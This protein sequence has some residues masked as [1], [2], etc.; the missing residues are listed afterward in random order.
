MKSRGSLMLALAGILTMI[1]VSWS[2]VS[3]AGMRCCYM[4]EV[5]D[6]DGFDQ[7]FVEFCEEIAGIAPLAATQTKRLVARLEVPEN[8]E[9]H[10]RDERDLNDGPLFKRE[11]ARAVKREV[12]RRQRGRSD[13]LRFIFKEPRED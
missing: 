4:G 10:L 12:K 7:A 2:P 13:R 5:V 11:G 6:A 9:A 8:L 3:L 1:L